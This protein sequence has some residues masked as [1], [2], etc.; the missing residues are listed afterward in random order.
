MT[1]PDENLDE[2]LHA[3]LTAP[4]YVL[5]SEDVR[6]LA[7]PELRP[8]RM[9]LELLKPELSLTHQHVRSTIVV[10]GS[11]QIGDRL[12]AETRLAA[13]EANLSLAPDDLRAQRQVAVAR[14]LLD[15][16]RYYD[17]AREF[18]RIVSRASQ[19]HNVCDYVMITG[20]GPGIME[21][22]NRGAH[23]VGA[24]SIGLNITLPNEQRP[25]PY[26]TPSLCFRFQY[27]AIRKMHFLLR[28]RALL[29][30]P[31]GFGTLDEFFDAITLRQTRRLQE[32]PIILYGRSYW[33]RVIDFQ[34]LADEGVIADEDLDLFQYAETPA[35]A[36]DQIA[37]YHRL[38]QTQDR[39]SFLH[40]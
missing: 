2:Q 13:A 27:F 26:I 12:H 31:G 1:A 8:L 5:A 33:E 3:L 38:R 37:H 40:D 28:A 6:L 36:W 23:D 22:A 25:N 34:F 15:K 9:H 24:K 20:G 16:S 17:D 7:R 4:S 29:I 14:R 19:Q 32:I 39:D 30:F 21:A 10:F 11:T 35:E 18:S